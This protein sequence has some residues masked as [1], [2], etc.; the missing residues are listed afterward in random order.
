MLKDLRQPKAQRNRAIVTSALIL[1]LS[2]SSF[3]ALLPTANAANVT[4]YA[5]LYVGPNPI[6]VN[7]QASVVMWLDKIPPINEQN[8]ALTYDN[9]TLTITKPDGTT[10][11]MGPYKSDYI[12]SKAILYTPDQVG[13]YYFQFKFLGQVINSRRAAGQ[14]LSN[15]SYLASTSPKMPLTVQ[16][17]PIA[18]SYPAAELPTQ[19]WNRPIEEENREWWTIGGNWLGVP[20]Q[21]ATG[22]DAIGSFNP[23]S[24]APNSAH[25]VWT[26][27]LLFGGIVGGDLGDKSYYTGLSYEEKWN[28]PTVVAING[29][30]YYHLPLSNWP[31]GGGLACVDIRTGEQYWWQ[32]ISIN[33]GQL[34]NFDS[35]NQ[36]GVIPYLWSTGSTYTMYDA[37]YGNPVLTMANASTGRIIYDDN[38]NMLVY[39]MNAARNWLALWNSTKVRRTHNV[40]R[41][42]GRVSMET[43]CCR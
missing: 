15:D 16:S 8:A 35:M 10:T 23:Y 42:S 5:Y 41:G 19:Y 18:T 9:Y 4:T 34:L 22:Y 39:V 38:G 29:R 27:P 36:H 6:G 17:T 32:N 14:P 40:N 28:P 21:F 24:K 43:S 20:L 30:L 2:L 7:Q 11:N 1:L 13:T 26:K 3:L 12:G 37:V 33:L 25:V 31:T